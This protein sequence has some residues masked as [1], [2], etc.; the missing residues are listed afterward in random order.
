MSGANLMDRKATYTRAQF[1]VIIS[2]AVAFILILLAKDYFLGALF[3]VIIWSYLLSMELLTTRFL[4]GPTT[5]NEALDDEKWLKVQTTRNGFPVDGRLRLQEGKA[6]MMICLHGWSSSTARMGP[7]MRDFHRM[8]MHTMA[9]EYRNHGDGGDTKEWTS[10]K[11]VD[12]L[13]QLMAD[14]IDRDSVSEVYLYGHSMGA[15]IIFAASRICDNSWWN[16]S[17]KGAILESPMTSY[18]EV[19]RRMTTSLSVLRIPLKRRLLR[20]WK[21]IHPETILFKWEDSQLP[22]WGVPKCPLLVL[23]APNDE[24]LSPLHFELLIDILEGRLD[25]ESHI[26]D[27]LTHGKSAVD[28]NRD[29]LIESW[30]KKRLTLHS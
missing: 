29:A 13:D 21:S 26:V 19:F 30:L 5:R 4:S 3:A 20:A 12:D 2:V 18:P 6:P 27:G 15:F 9:L 17:V 8:G 10:M 1:I 25:V 28:E 14:C 11:V 24:V 23:Q 22:A 16:K 7:L